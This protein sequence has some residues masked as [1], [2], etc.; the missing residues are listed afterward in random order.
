MILRLLLIAVVVW[1][2]ISVLRRILNRPKTRK[3]GTRYGGK[4]V[5]CEVCGVYLPIDDATRGPNE[6][7]YC[8]K[9]RSGADGG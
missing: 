4:M 3:I 6:I 9:H 1:L 2:A 7:Y 5:A 8:E